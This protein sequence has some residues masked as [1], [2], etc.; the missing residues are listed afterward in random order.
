MLP[1]TRISNSHSCS[2][3]FFFGRARIPEFINL[4]GTSSNSVSQNLL[5]SHTTSMYHFSRK[6]FMHHDYAKHFIAELRLFSLILKP[7]IAV[8]YQA[9][10]L[11]ARRHLHCTLHCIVCQREEAKSNPH[12]Q[13]PLRGRARWARQRSRRRQGPSLRLRRRRCVA[14]WQPPGTPPPSWGAPPTPPQLPIWPARW[15][16]RL[17]L[18]FARLCL[19]LR[20][21]GAL[22]QSLGG[23]PRLPSIHEVLLQLLHNCWFGLCFDDS[24]TISWWLGRRYFV[25]KQALMLWTRVIVNS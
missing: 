13:P 12:L 6:S 21:L 5:L 1:Q 17:F 2:P 20:M 18:G 24:F 4:A 9:N 3:C 16:T 10:P 7:F 11:I 25:M 15:F 22:D 19:V 23:R 14:P 8:S